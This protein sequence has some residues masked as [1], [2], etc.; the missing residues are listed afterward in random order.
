LGS[1]WG[2]SQGE[3]GRLIADNGGNSSGGGHMVNDLAVRRLTGSAF[4][5][6]IAGCFSIGGEGLSHMM[7]LLMASWP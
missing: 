1:F 7:Q 2:I 4:V 5:S 3:Q 6:A